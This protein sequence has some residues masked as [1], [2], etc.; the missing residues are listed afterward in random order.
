MYITFE[1]TSRNVFIFCIFDNSQHLAS[2][3]HSW[4]PKRYIYIYI[5]ALDNIY[6][7]Y[8]YVFAMDVLYTSQVMEVVKYGKIA[9]FYSF[10]W[11]WVLINPHSTKTI[12]NQY[13]IQ[14]F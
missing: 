6:I 12:P 14:I 8:Q 13:P 11:I 2:I 9:Y 7:L 5:T 1:E 10:C 3:E 4:I